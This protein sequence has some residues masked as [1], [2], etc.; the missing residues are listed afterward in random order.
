MK[1][2]EVS[3]ENA[4]NLWKENTVLKSG[5]ARNQAIA[6]RYKVEAEMEKRITTQLEDE[7]AQVEFEANL[8]AKEFKR[9][10]VWFETKLK[11]VTLDSNTSKARGK[12]IEICMNILMDRHKNRILLR[13]FNRM[14]EHKM[15]EKIQEGYKRDMIAN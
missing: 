7:I 8:Q 11:K 5:L 12:A 14:Y 4:F 15:L 2:G 9:E 6:Q 13:G 3:L 1:Q 10:E